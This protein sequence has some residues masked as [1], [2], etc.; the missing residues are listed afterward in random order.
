MSAFRPKLKA[1]L[2]NE[3]G[4]AVAGE[5]PDESIGEIRVHTMQVVVLDTIAY[6]NGVLNACASMVKVHRGFERMPALLPKQAD[7]DKT[8]SNTAEVLRHQFEQAGAKAEGT[9]PRGKILR[10]QRAMVL[11]TRALLRKVQIAHDALPAIFIASKWQ[12][13]AWKL[14]QADLDVERAVV[15]QEW[16]D[17]I[18]EFMAMMAGNPR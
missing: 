3:R 15:A 1:V 5:I 6:V 9:S 13:C 11:Q 2:R 12:V 8:A 18:D 16:K 7:V 4:E 17:A 14:G 10:A